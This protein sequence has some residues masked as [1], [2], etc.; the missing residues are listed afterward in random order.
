MYSISAH[1]AVYILH[2][3]VGTPRTNLTVSFRDVYSIASQISVSLSNDPVQFHKDFIQLV[4][5]RAPVSTL[6]DSTNSH[7]SKDV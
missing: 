3:T 6:H 5:I 1:M 4:D 7:C 2:S